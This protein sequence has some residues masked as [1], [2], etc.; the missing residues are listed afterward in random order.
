MTSSDPNAHDPLEALP[1]PQAA[2]AGAGPADILVLDNDERIVELVSWF[3]GKRGF[4]VRRA[5]SFAEARVALADGLPDLMLSDLDL[6]AESALDE[7]P[8]LAE[9]GMLPPTLVVSGYLDQ[10]STER[11]LAVPG[12]LGTLPK[13]FDFELLE[14]RVLECLAA[15]PAPVEVAPAAS[16]AAEHAQVERSSEGWVE[17]RPAR[18]AASEAPV[19]DAPAPPEGA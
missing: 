13:P 6:G 19:S 2:S 9:Q 7:L 5:H 3:L 8:V 1:V 14:A 16:E 12:V 4:G 17:I 10:D 15:R 18:P 11:L